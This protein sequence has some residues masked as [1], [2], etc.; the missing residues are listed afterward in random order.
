M[1]VKPPM[2]TVIADG[3]EMIVL[4]EDDTLIRL[5]PEQFWTDSAVTIAVLV[6]AATIL[7]LVATWP[8][9]ARRDRSMLAQDAAQARYREALEKS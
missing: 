9:K 8:T 4:A 2:D 1:A 3:D 7:T 5:F 6:L